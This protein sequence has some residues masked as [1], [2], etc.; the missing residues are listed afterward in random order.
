MILALLGWA[1]AQEDPPA[2]EEPAV[3]RTIVVYS[4]EQVEAAREE[5]IE[6]LENMGYT[7]RIEKDGAVVMRHDQPWKGEV[8]LHDDGWM[9]IK[10]QPVRIEA[11]ASAFGPRNSAGSW[12]GCILLPFR[13]IRTGGQFVS[14]RKFIAQETRAAE[15][16]VEQVAAWSD[17]VADFR[18]TEKVDALPARMDALWND[19][20]P[21]EGEGHLAT[22]DERKLALL[23]YWESRTDNPWGEAVREAVESFLVGVVQDS[24]TPITP[25]ELMAFNRRSRASR[26]LVLD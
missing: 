18:V 9:R 21:L 2:P 14:K 22:V 11:P 26:P 4:R 5:V 8:W 10:R 13:C 3:S 1:L 12:A 20:V 16:V 7:R 19:G 15:H 23:S 24:E 17:K 6:D 25:D